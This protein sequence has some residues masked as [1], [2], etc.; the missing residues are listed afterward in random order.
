MVNALIPQRQAITNVL[1]ACVG[2]AP[3][4]HMLL[5]QR[6]RSC[7]R[8][9]SAPVKA[10]VPAAVASGAVDKS[11]AASKMPAPSAKDQDI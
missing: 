7:M 4:N 3:Q 5:E 6:V 11:G 8:A 1:R 2:L 9:P 10:A